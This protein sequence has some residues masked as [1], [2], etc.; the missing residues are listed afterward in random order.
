MFAVFLSNFKQKIR[1]RILKT[2]HVIEQVIIRL[3]VG[4]YL[5]FGDPLEQS[6][7]LQPFLRHW[8]LSILWSRPWPF[9]VTCRHRSRDHC[10]R[11]GPFPIG[12]PLH[13]V[14]ISNGFRDI[15][16]RTPRRACCPVTVDCHV[17][18]PGQPDRRQ[19]TAGH[20]PTS[21]SLLPHHRQLPV[22][23]PGQPTRRQTIPGHV[24]TS[25]RLLLHHRRLPVDTPG[26][27]DWW[28]TSGG[29]VYRQRRAYC[30]ITV[31]CQ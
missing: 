1:R 9:S 21:K 23:T 10:T 13:Q 20:L 6:L 29:H 2:G 12:G 17:D 24:P 5:P 31:N 16:P 30:H 22:V 28:R 19:T 27:P 15:P 7:C 8:A 11:D 4:H 25:K 3:A 18:T 14:S 26:Q